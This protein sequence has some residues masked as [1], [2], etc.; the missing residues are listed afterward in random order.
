[1]FED[2]KIGFLEIIAFRGSA[3]STIAMLG[4]VIWSIISGKVH[5]PVLL[6]DTFPQAKLHIYNLKT[7]LE[8][9]KLLIGDFGPF[10]EKE[11]WTATNIVLPRYDARIVV[12]STGQ[13]IR[14][15]RHKQY[16][17]D[18]FLI[19]D[20]ENLDMVRTQEQRNKTFR[21]FNGDVIPAGTN[22]TR[23]VLI[24]NLLHSDAIMSRIKQEIVGKLRDGVVREYPFL[25]NGTAIWPEKYPTGNDIEREKRKVNDER[26][27]QREYLLKIIPEEGQEIKD[28]WIKY[29]DRIPDLPIQHQGTGVD[30]AISKK[31][32][33]NYTAMV[34]GKLV[35][36]DDKPKIYIMPNPV[37]ERLSSH[38]TTERARAVSLALGGSSLTSLWVEEVGYQKAAIEAMERAGL[39]A[40]GV[41]VSTDKRARLRTIATYVQNGTIVFP[42][43]GC[44][45][46]IIQL[47]GFGVEAHDDLVDAFVYLI[48][49]LMNLVTNEP[50]IT[51][52]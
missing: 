10:G 48:Q 28:D 39:P 29:Y 52:F 41:R 50:R 23:Y 32:T 16:R 36:E 13:K 3:K 1:M 42:K 38:E 11:E 25:I 22:E 35:M 37:N 31:E 46:L 19:D 5:F 30:L 9:N 43:S 40:S 4:F 20:I 45:D 18:L 47:T 51:I 7:E 17:P 34:S 44:E 49:A 14:G 6:S 15:M 24:G 26:A 12:K 21:W 33:A 8:N 27:W 2:W